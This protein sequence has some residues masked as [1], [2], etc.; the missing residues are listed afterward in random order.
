MA[1]PE[2][3]PVRGF[4]DCFTDLVERR[5]SELG[6]SWAGVYPRS[7]RAEA[8][9]RAREEMVRRIA[10]RGG[11]RYAESTVARWAAR[12]HWPPGVETFWLER[13]ATIDRAGGIAA[14]AASL[15]S[16]P[17]RVI[18]WRDST[19][20][21]ARPPAPVRGVP[22]EPQVIGVSVD[23]FATVGTTRIDKKIPAGK[24]ARYQELVLDPD[25]GVLAAW[26]ANDTD[27]LVELLGDLIAEQ[28]ISEWHSA[29]FYTIDYTVTEILLFLPNLDDQ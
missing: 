8:A 13:W 17:A 26:F 12:N 24:G 3:E 27:R 7:R 22:G 28:I 21:G 6:G 15:R 16:T 23:G 2:P 20:P 9:R 14:L 29:Q 10:I 5:L 4:K 11:R 19:D 18:S 25:P 1:A